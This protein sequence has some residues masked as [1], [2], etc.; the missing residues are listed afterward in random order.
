VSAATFDEHEADTMV[1]HLLVNVCRFRDHRDG[2]G[3]A[4]ARSDCRGVRRA[5]RRSR[6]GDRSRRSRRLRPGGRAQGRP[7]RPDGPTSSPTRGRPRRRP[8]HASRSLCCAFSRAHAAA[9]ALCFASAAAKRLFVI[10]VGAAKLFSKACSVSAAPRG[11]VM[12][13]E[14]VAQQSAVQVLPRISSSSKTAPPSCRA[15]RAQFQWRRSVE[16]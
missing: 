1:E 10:E 12:I 9:D 15:I 13:N 8:G 7:S 6:G 3:V 5:T 2:V 4:Q 11:R 16:R 14:P